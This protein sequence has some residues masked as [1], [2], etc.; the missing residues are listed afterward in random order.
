MTAG[1]LAMKST[2]VGVINVEAKQL[3]EEGIR[4]QLVKKIVDVLYEHLQTASVTNP[5]K[6]N[7][8]IDSVGR[9][10]DG[11]R[12]SFEYMG[13]YVNMDGLRIWH[14]EYSRVMCFLVEQESN[15]F[16]R[17]KIQAW[18]SEFQSKVAPIVIPKSNG[19]FATCIGQFMGVLIEL[20]KLEAGS[21]CGITGGWL[22]RVSGEEILG[23]KT[24]RRMCNAIGIEGTSS[25]DDLLSF[26]LAEKLKNFFFAFGK[27]GFGIFAGQMNFLLDLWPS[28][29]R[30][31]EIYNELFARIKPDVHIWSRHICKIGQIQLLKATIGTHM[32]LKCELEAQALHF[33]LRNANTTVL[34]A[35]K[36]FYRDPVHNPYPSSQLIGALSSYLENCGMSEP[37]EKIFTSSKPSPE[38]SLVLFALTILNLNNSKLVER[39][40]LHMLVRNEHYGHYEFIVGVITI[41]RQMNVQHTYAYLTFLGQYTN[42]LL[43]EPMGPLKKEQNGGIEI[44]RPLR[45][46]L[47]FVKDFEILAKCPRRMVDTFISPT[48]FDFISI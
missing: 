32:K 8:M 13:D 6:F 36:Q 24:I 12:S 44:S 15:R 48:I 33:M 43:A 27:S 31:H 2:V 16:L 11:I 20:T 37:L 3:L 38:M 46:V 17:K 10:I 14:H 42:L 23:T 39:S 29:P 18:Q 35:I 47:I 1:V 34:Q 40:E 41:L 7:Q 45:N 30:S 28:P 26:E 9:A 5:L 4:K 19:P 25:V 22:N 21:Y